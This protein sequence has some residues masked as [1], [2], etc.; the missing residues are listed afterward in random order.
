MGFTN[1][2]R[3][4]ILPALRCRERSLMKLAIMKERRP[5]EARVAASPDSV[6]RLG[7]L[8]FTVVVETGAGLRAAMPDSA[9]VAAGAAIAPD[10]ASLLAD[11]DIILK[12][13]R[14]TTGA[15]GTVDE[16]GAMRRGAVLIG[17]LAPYAD[18]GLLQAY[19]DRGIA[20]FAMELLPRITRA[21]TMDVLSSQANLAGYR[22]VLEA[23]PVSYTHLTLP[24]SDLV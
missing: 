13:Q 24:T 15:D 3:A 16:L 8:G 18:R 20:A 7:A 5:G 12:V 1:N 4:C 11:A 23:A 2:R 22:A 17:M 10:T 6:K 9:Y 21:Q 19:A 14:P